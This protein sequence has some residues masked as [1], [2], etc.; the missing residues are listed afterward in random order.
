MPRTSDFS[1]LAKLRLAQI[2]DTELLGGE[3]PSVTL[4]DIT[5]PEGDWLNRA[6]VVVPYLN[7]ELEVRGSHLRVEEVERYYFDFSP[8]GPVL[9]AIC[10]LGL[11]DPAKQ[12]RRL[13]MLGNYKPGIKWMPEQNSGPQ[14]EKDRDFLLDG[15]RQRALRDQIPAAMLGFLIP[16]TARVRAY[17][18]GRTLTAEQQ[19]DLNE[20]LKYTP[21]EKMEL[22][23]LTYIALA[24]GT[25]LEEILAS[26]S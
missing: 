12:T 24:L 13:F 6:A 1:D 11:I 26:S 19:R 14:F 9:G 17:V 16:T 20:V 2:I 22:K 8:Y 4:H 25:T 15:A 5:N 3:T 7:A 18:E 21:W 10:Y 23:N